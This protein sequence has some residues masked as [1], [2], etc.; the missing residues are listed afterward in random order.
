MLAAY[1]KHR[2]KLNGVYADVMLSNPLEDEDRFRA[3]IGAAIEAGEVEAYDKFVNE[4]KRSKDARM[5]KARNEA[6]EAEKEAAG[7]ERYQSIF[8]KKGDGGVSTA[9]TNGHQASKEMGLA[10]L[11]QA[12]NKGRA[13]T[14]LDGLE[15]KYAGK[16]GTKRRKED[17]PPEEAFQRNVDRGKEKTTKRS[18][19]G[20]EERFTGTGKKRKKTEAGRREELNETT[21]I[22]S[23]KNLDGEK[24][25]EDEVDEVEEMESRLGKD[26]RKISSRGRPQKAKRAK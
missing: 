16:K 12:R 7:N 25:K 11:I 21:P 22:A 4:P 15:Q 3:Y 26:K 24:S 13:A 19:E 23:N 20:M 18:V 10:E 5:R 14:F 17:E 8:G 6:K 2:G 9:A 1:T